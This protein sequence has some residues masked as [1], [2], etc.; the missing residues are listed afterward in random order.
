MRDCVLIFNSEFTQKE[1]F[2]RFKRKKSLIIPCPTELQVHSKVCT[3]SN[4]LNQITLNFKKLILSVGTIEPRKNQLQL[5]EIF[6]NSKAS[7]NFVLLI[8]GSRGNDTNYFLKFYQKIIN[9]RNVMFLDKICDFCLLL[10]YQNVLIFISAS[11]AEGFDIPAH[12]AGNAGAA[13][14]LSDIPVHRE[15]FNNAIWF[16]PSNKDSFLHALNTLDFQKFVDSHRPVNYAN[17]KNLRN[18]L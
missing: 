3:K 13:L 4:C 16:D 9:Q 10:L 17:I 6:L 8:V 15:F 14:I 18:L 7:E 1:Y 11:F 12:E 5:V 2:L